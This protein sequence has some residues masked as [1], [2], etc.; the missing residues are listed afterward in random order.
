MI[1]FTEARMKVRTAT[2]SCIASAVAPV[3][4]SDAAYADFMEMHF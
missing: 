4:A 3:R 2:P 1:N